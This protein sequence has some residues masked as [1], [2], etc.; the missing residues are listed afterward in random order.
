[1][2]TR[3]IIPI[4]VLFLVLSGHASAINLNSSPISLE[5]RPVDQVSAGKTCNL[6]VSLTGQAINALLN[7]ILQAGVVGS[8]AK[9]CAHVNGT[10]IE[11]TACNVL[12]DVVGIKAFVAALKD[13]DLDPIYFCELLKSCPAG[14]DS[15]AAK[16]TGVVVTP[17]A[18]GPSGTK[19]T[20]ELDFTVTN[21]TG[22]GEIRVAIHG[23]TTADVGQGFLNTGFPVGPEA[24]RVSVDTT[25]QPFP[26]DPNQQPIIWNPGSYEVSF[27]VCQGECGSKHPHSIMLGQISK[28]FT[29]TPGTLPPPAAALTPVTMSLMPGLRMDGASHYEDPSPDGCQSDE[30]KIEIQ[31]L[32]GD[33][34]SPACDGSSCPTDVPSGVT[35]KPMCALQDSSSKKKYRALICTPS[36]GDAQCG[37]NGSCKSIQSVGVCTYDD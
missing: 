5:A 18:G 10:K 36:A 21:A 16:L 22:T 1:M 2:N 19:F 11:K 27:A 12:C 4:A 33:F 15:A 17:A 32:K 29:I 28:N 6:C 30:V 20:F 8:C 35:A 13:A 37:A 26:K 34:C 23:P 25:S 9:L 14:P 7:Y 31:G 3:A 24:A